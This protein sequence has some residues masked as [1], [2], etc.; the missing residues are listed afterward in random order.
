[1]KN[2]LIVVNSYSYSSNIEYKVRR[3]EEELRKFNIDVD[4]RKANELLVSTNGNTVE[5]TLLKKYLFCIYLDKDNY[6]AKAISLTIPMY[7]NYESL[8]LSDDKMLSILALKDSNIISPKT[9]SAPL[10]YTESPQENEVEKFLD[11]IEKE[12]SF[13]LVFKLC[14]GSLG[15]QVFLIRDREEL[16]LYYNK[17]K[18]LPHIYE[19]YLTAHIGDDYRLIVIGD[20]VVASM[21]RKNENDFRSNIALGGKGYDVTN[22]VP[23]IFKKVA[24]EVARRLKLDYAGIDLAI[25]KDDKPIFIEANGNAFFTEIEKVTSINIARQLVEHILKKEKII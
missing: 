9:I 5:D 8:I 17:Y 22:V 24:V 13:P 12:L 16:K 18:N 14:H 19:E 23:D 20:K 15:K 10:C 25:S 3:L 1:M 2:V 7:N 21:E 4:I 6:L 11:K